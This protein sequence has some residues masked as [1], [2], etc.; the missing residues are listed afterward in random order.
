MRTC[1]NT[2]ICV[3]STRDN[4]LKFTKLSANRL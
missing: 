3:V 4:K 2:H 1:K